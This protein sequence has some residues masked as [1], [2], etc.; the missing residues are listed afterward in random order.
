MYTS[1]TGHVLYEL[2]TNPLPLA[3]NSSVPIDDWL[4]IVKLLSP[5]HTVFS[6]WLD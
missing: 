3:C 4:S 6:V 1:C 5:L 2:R